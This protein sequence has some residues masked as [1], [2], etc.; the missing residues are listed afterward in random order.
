[1][2]GTIAPLVQRQ[3]K[4]W[5]ISVSTFIVAGTIAGLSLG[6]ALGTASLMGAR[7]GLTRPVMV[8]LLSAVTLLAGGID[9]GVV[10][11]ALPNP[12]R[13][14]PQRWW[15]EHDPIGASAAYGFVLGLGI[16]TAIPFASFYIVLV[17]S[18]VGGA[19]IGALV[20]AVYGFSRSVTV[21]IASGLILFG[22]EP[23]GV[24]LWLVR[25]TFTARTTSGIACI[26]L[27]VLWFLQ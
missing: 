15:L 25:H 14:V 27:S 8:Y 17:C 2:V 11:V 13:S 21:L 6:L 5:L 20:G 3:K 26:V 23:R 24:G 16:T 18:F 1:M 4:Q 7:F 12:H 19:A 9:L 10:N 22:A